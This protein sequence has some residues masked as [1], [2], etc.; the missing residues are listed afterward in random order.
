M[1]PKA[2]LANE[3]TR[4]GRKTPTMSTIRIV[5][6]HESPALLAK[7]S[8]EYL[9]PTNPTERDLSKWRTRRAS[10]VESSTINYKM[11]EQK[12]D[13]EAN[14]AAL[15]QIQYK[16]VRNLRGQQDSRHN[17]QSKDDQTDLIPNTDIR[18]NLKV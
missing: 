2:I 11:D 6:N 5:L 12:G 3:Q 1:E 9:Q 13:V 8:V 15:P 4:K 16:Q 14:S 18:R 7:L 10:R 17:S